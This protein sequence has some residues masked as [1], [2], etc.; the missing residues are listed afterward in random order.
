MGT[1]TGIS[2][3]QPT[4]LTGV[5]VAPHQFFSNLVHLGRQKVW[6]KRP[7]PNV[8]RVGNPRSTY[9]VQDEANHLERVGVII[10]RRE[11]VPGA[12]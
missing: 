6:E 8:I 2:P 4:Y 11:I 1:A 3:R 9:L 5:A 10:R 7:I 12:S